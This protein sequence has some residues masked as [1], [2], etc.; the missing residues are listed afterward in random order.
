MPSKAV[1]V[2]LVGAVVTAVT[3]A[4]VGPMI[5]WAD[6]APTAKART[7]GTPLNVRTAPSVTAA[8]LRTLPDGSA[9]ALA[10][11]VSGQRITG[12]VRT[13]TDWD[14][15]DGGGYVS[16]AYVVR[17]R[18]PGTCP[19]RTGVPERDRFLAQA[20]PLAQQGMRTYAVPAS[21]TLAQA[22]LESGWGAS[23][24]SRDH[25]NFFGIKCFHGVHGPIAAACHTYRTH[26]CDRKG[27]CHATRA[28]FRGYW[29][30]RDSF[31]DHG[32]F[33]TVNSRYRG[34]FRHSHAPDRFARAVAAAGYATSPAYGRDLVEL[35]RRYDLYRYDR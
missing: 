11:R 7:A 21:V 5:G 18:R 31:R 34:A 28:S 17:P 27:R 23:A 24:L 16:D 8:R 20:A 33:L 35:M 6:P 3:A 12:V 14:R 26:E 13:T 1:V 9:L 32:R 29:S 4:V 15:L 2:A 22:I 25:D 10:C 30:M 19:G